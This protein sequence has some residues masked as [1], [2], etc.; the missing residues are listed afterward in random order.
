MD[1]FHA[2]RAVRAARHRIAQSLLLTALPLAAGCTAEHGPTLVDAAPALDARLARPDGTVEAAIAVPWDRPSDAW[3]GE[4]ALTADAAIRCALSENRM[5]RRTLAE[6]D[7]RR[8]ALGDAQLAPNPTLNLAVGAPLD[9]G[10]VP[11]LAMLAAQVDWL[12]KRDAI[13]GEADAQ[14][15]SMLLESAAMVVATVAEVRG[16]Y[17]EAAS[18]T[19]QAE[20]ARRDAEVAARVLRAEESALAA[21]ESGRAAVNRARMN[22]AEAANRV[23]EADVAAVSAKTRLLEAIGR[24]SHHLRWSIAAGGV[25]QAVAECPL[26]E[27]PAGDD[28]EA[29]AALVGERRLDIRAAEARAEGAEARAALAATGRLPTLMLGAGYEQDMEAGQSAMVMLESQLPVF[30]D[31]RFRVAAARA[32]AEI[33][34]IDADRVRQRAMIDARRAVAE[35]A[36]AE[37]HA[38]TLRTRT[39][40]AFAASRMLLAQAVDAGERRAVDLWRSEHQENHYRLQLARAERDRALACI[41]FER[42][43]AGGRL[44]SMPGAG[45]AGGGMGSGMGSA[46]AVSAGPMPD[47][48]FTALEE[49]E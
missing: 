4:A 44:P 47:F 2:A 31:G 48:G 7:R 45:G 14:L 40:E 35:V 15:R 17:I 18:A 5:L 13:V 27:V 9:M 20:L 38:A 25:A 12:W 26:P 41:A 46:G 33:A 3:D 30:N 42:A 22:A 8:A 23:M 39:I 32:D 29:L 10:V 1:R 21:G 19:E 6:A 24:G 16:A 49:M 37:H 34:R 43:L 11:V 36:A 28:H